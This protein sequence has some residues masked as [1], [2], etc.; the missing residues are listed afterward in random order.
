M[1]SR[2][3][4]RW[5]SRGA[6][7]AVV[8]STLMSA[9]PGSADAAPWGGR[10]N[11]AAQEFQNLWNQTDANS[12]NRSLTW[13]PSPWWDYK[14]FYKDAPGGLR[15]VQYFDKARMEI[16][17][18]EAAKTPFFVT[19]GLL[20]VEMISGRVKLG[21]NEDASSYDQRESAGI[22]VAGDLAKVNPNA[23]TYA[24]FRLVATTSGNNQAQPRLGERISATFDK[25]GNIGV[26][27]DLATEATQIVQ[28][29]ANTGHNIPAVF[30]DYMDFYDRSGNVGSIF[31]FGYPITEPYWI[32]AR[33]G[34]QDMD[35]MVQIFERRVLTYTP[36]NPEQYQVEMGNVGQHYFQWRYANQGTPWDPETPPYFPVAFASNRPT[37]TKTIERIY[38]TDVNG[39]NQSPITPDTVAARPTS[40]LRSWD[41]KS[42]RI[43]GEVTADNKRRIFSYALDGSQATPVMQAMQPTDGDDYQASVS[44]DGTKIVFVSNR[45]TSKNADKNAELFMMNL[46][47]TGLVQLTD[48]KAPCANE[49]PTFRGDGSGIVWSSNCGQANWEVVRANLG[50]SQDKLNDIQATL[51]T[52]VN[53]TKNE[54]NDRYPRVSPDGS[55]VAFSSDRGSGKFDL[56]V[57]SVDSG[58]ALQALT[59]SANGNDIAP[60]WSPDSLQLIY[61]SDIEGDSEIYLRNL[62]ART[63]PR[64][65]TNNSTDDIS[66]I[67]A[68]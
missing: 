23:P 48:T 46:N 19:N 18:P 7:A 8:G 14:E 38:T 35:V 43:I 16:N 22:P 3:S 31:T 39:N 54:A 58:S 56:Y 20:P 61:Q 64:Q 12:G 33:V 34:G 52:W 60:T 42:I 6:A 57:M 44:P 59:T 17:N 15:Q 26:R 5:L 24:S 50:Y 45:T 63:A 25:S 9:L 49:N 55:K 1:N 37:G 67:W 32:R 40:V 29:N 62:D 2:R 10:N 65:L 4:F 13:G 28:F 51:S 11:F 30:K 36:S 47:G 68:Q 21:N 66:P 41:Q 53:L 27:Q